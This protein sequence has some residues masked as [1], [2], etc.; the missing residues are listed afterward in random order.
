MYY[1]DILV[2]TVSWKSCTF[3]EMDSVSEMDCNGNARFTTNVYITYIT[4]A[5]GIYVVKLKYIFYSSTGVV[6]RRDIING[7]R[8]YGLVLVLIKQIR[9]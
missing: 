8:L 3:C 5:F 4:L 2:C 1:V 6:V 9:L 7:M